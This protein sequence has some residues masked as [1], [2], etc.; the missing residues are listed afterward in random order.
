MQ[1]SFI[2]AAKL[3]VEPYRAGIYEMSTN[4]IR[5]ACGPLMK[6]CLESLKKGKENPNQPSNQTNKNPSLRQL[7]L[8]LPGPYAGVSG[9]LAVTV[10]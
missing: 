3:S 9:S 1:I 5:S 10:A 6:A 4:I 8:R 7:T 2:Y